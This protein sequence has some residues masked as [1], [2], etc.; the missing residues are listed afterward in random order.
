MADFTITTTITG[1]VNG[2]ALTVEHDFT[3]EDVVSAIEDRGYIQGGAPHQT[4]NAGVYGQR[5][6]HQENSVA[7][8]CFFAT[9]PYAAQV[10]FNTGGTPLYS[11]AAMGPFVIH[12]GEGFNGSI[13]SATSLPPADPSSE[14]TNVSFAGLTPYEYRSIALIKPVS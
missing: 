13:G 5:G 8:A 12:H 9:T 14:I 10:V 11:G 3:L 7:Y 1:S 2:Q 4:L 6:Q